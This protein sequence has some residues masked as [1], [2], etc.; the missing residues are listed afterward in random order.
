MIN[1]YK[2][3]N[4]RVNITENMNLDRNSECLKIPTYDPFAESLTNVS[5]VYQAV[6]ANI[7]ARTGL[8]LHHRP[9][10]HLLIADDP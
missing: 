5:K 4:C 2:Q 9:T 10:V 7:S 3:K 8:R 1:E 6:L